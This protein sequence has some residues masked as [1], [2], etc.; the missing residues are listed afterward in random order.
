VHM[1]FDKNIQHFGQVSNAEHEADQ[2]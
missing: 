2:V 1:I